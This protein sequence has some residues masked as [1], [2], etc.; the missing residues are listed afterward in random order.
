MSAHWRTLLATQEPLPAVRGC[1]QEA[2]GLISGMQQ[3]SLNI[4]A[5]TESAAI[6]AC[7]RAARW[8]HAI[9]LFRSMRAEHC[10][11]NVVSYN[12]V[13]AACGRSGNW[14]LATSVLD[15]MQN[16]Q[17]APDAFSFNT[18]VSACERSTSWRRSLWLWTELRRRDFDVS[19]VGLNAT[20][21]ALRHHGA[22]DL[23]LGVFEGFCIQGQADAQ[24]YFALIGSCAKASRWREAL[25]LLRTSEALSNDALCYMAASE[26]CEHAGQQ[27]PSGRILIDISRLRLASSSSFGAQV[28][29]L[30]HLRCLGLPPTTASR[31]SRAASM[32]YRRVLASLR[33]PESQ[34]GLQLP[35]SAS[36]FGRCFSQDVIEELGQG[37]N[38]AARPEKQGQRHKAV[39][40]IPCGMEPRASKLVAIVA[41]DL[42][43]VCKAS[44][45][46]ASKA[47]TWHLRSVMTVGLRV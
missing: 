26:A 24:S 41:F 42:V 32:P 11:T 45:L 29:V 35:E 10:H 13:L 37:P 12:A 5:A 14:R 34:D 9:Q 21:G 3:Q 25:A 7:S 28:K 36:D 31:A 6:S 19:T 43:G 46:R 15:E 8:A 23:A 27:A 38:A 17:Y 4:D 39:L 47:N 22:W 16:L 20:L 44:K 1:W 18:L 40:R 30:N 33:A 2:L